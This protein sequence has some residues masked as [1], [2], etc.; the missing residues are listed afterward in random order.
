MKVAKA[1]KVVLRGQD[2][3]DMIG[4]ITRYDVNAYHKG[5]AG[6]V[7]RK[8]KYRVACLTV[9]NDGRPLACNLPSDD[10]TSDHYKIIATDL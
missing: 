2:P 10:D 3:N 7:R 6:K 9:L 4:S 1:E 8:C 5:F